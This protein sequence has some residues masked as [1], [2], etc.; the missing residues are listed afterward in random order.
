MGNWVVRGQY[1]AGLV[2]RQPAL[3]YREEERVHPTSNTETYVAM[4]VAIDN[5]RWAGVPFFLRTGKRLPK[6]VTEIA[7]QFKKPPLNLFTTVECEGDLCDLVD[8]RPNQ[9]ILR[10]QPQEAI[11]LRFSTKRPGMQYQVQPVSMDFE[12]E[13]HFQSHLPEAYERL[14][15]DVIR[16]DST[17]FT[18]SDEL[19]AA[20]RFL[21]PVLDTW[22]NSS[23]TPDMYPAGTWGPSTSDRL[24]SECKAT[25]RTPR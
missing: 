14:L 24:I 7:I 3:G 23:A 21:T 20:W 10:I 2:N 17:L 18:R 15:L 25:W 9:L 13:D 19:E 1:T 5:W 6:Q 11:S 8:T 12:Y 22:K 4:R 16:G